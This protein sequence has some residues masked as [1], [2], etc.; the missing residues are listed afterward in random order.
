MISVSEARLR[1]GRIYQRKFA[2]WAADPSGVFEPVVLGLKPPTDRQVSADMAAV[3]QWLQE[4][5][6]VDTDE[7]R[8]AWE[9]RRWPNSGTQN[10][11]VRLEAGTPQALAGFLGQSR[12]WTLH[13]RRAARLLELHPA[14]EGESAGFTAAVAKVLAKA[15][16]LDEDDFG[17]VFDVLAWLEANPES[18]LFPRQLPV[19]GIDSKW[20]ER[21]AGIVRALHVALGGATDFGLGKPPKLYRARFLDSSL[22]PGGLDD[23]MAPA[24]ALAQLPIAPAT[25]LVIE[26]LQTLLSLPPMASVVALHGAG[27]DVR[28]T[29]Q[30]PWVRNARVLYWGDLD[31]D[32]L[33]ILAA[34]RSVLPGVQSVMMDTPTLQRFDHL[35]VKDPNGPVTTAPRGLTPGEREAFDLLRQN[36]GRR[37]EQERIDWAHAL[38]AIGQVLS[39]DRPDGTQ[40]PGTW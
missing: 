19:Q 25:V 21:H 39:P 15:G 24:S 36:G 37:L 6:R 10:I 29:V 5:S 3:G 2:A 7:V 4:W 17:R 33:G 8:I 22:A 38:G 16:A 28:W 23:L 26:N 20:L 14:G 18:G 9:T 32:G 31:A 12:H 30:L 35:T 34:L 27:Y 1:L 11:P 13:A 40:A